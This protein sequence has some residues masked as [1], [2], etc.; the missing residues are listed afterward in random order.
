MKINI[1]GRFVDEKDAKISVFDRSF[2]YGDAAFET[3]RGYAGVV[4]RLDAHIARMLSALEALKIKHA[5]T[6]KYLSGAVY[7]TLRANSLKNAYVRLVVTRGEGRFGIGYKDEFR[8]NLVIVAKEFEGYPEWMSRGISARITG[9]V[10]EY[11]PLSR[12]KTANYLGLI[13][14]RSDAKGRG[15]DEAVLTN[16]RDEVTEAAT[17]NIF[18]VKGRLL[19]TPAVSCG[20]LPGVTRAVIIETAKKLRIRA[21][22]R[23]VPRREL[24]AADE[25]FLTNSLAEV[26]PVTRVDSKKIGSGSV[27]PVTKLLHVSYQK[28]VIK[29]VLR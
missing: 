29:E 7:R 24:L 21:A 1:N 15:Y 4:F 9:V 16:T 10:N 11:S 17:S 3:M 14:A 27:G 12:L 18:L 22:E 13:L 19:V 2:L 26:L 28:Q 25:I 6:A 8:P 23:A 20:A 5:Y